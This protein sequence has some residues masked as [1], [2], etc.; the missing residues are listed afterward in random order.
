ML[1]FLKHRLVLLSMP[2]CGSTALETAFGRFADVVI[3]STPQ[4]KHTPFRKYDRFLRKYFETFT[5]CPLEVVCLFR[6]PVDWLGSWWRY[7]GRKELVGHENSTRGISFEDF[8]GSYLDGEGAPAR[9]GRQSQFVSNKAGEIGVDQIWRYDDLGGFADRLSQRLNVKM[10]V[11]RINVSPPSDG[12]T[13]SS[14]MAARI[15][16][17]LSRDFEIYQNLAKSAG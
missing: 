16:S 13:L 6:D 4:A 5:D 9:V 11:D 7:R 8:V 15:K 17:E 3:T 2:K 1:V 12:Q 14:D 10:T